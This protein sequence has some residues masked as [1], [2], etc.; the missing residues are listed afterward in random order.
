MRCG[1][2]GTDNREGRR[3]C[4]ECGAPMAATCPHCGAANEPGEKF[5]G[6]CGTT[7]SA[8]PRP[9]AAAQAAPAVRVAA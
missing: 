1:K 7:L 6:E 4:A 2:C 9:P 5:C 8:S 3:F